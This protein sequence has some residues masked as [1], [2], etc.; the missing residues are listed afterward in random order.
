MIL[1]SQTGGKDAAFETS[2]NF[3]QQELKID[4]EPAIS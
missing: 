3:L 2:A 4:F 1:T